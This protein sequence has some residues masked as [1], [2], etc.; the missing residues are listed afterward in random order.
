MEQRLRRGRRGAQVRPF[1]EQ[2]RIGNREYSLPLQRALADFGA[3]HSFV[4]ASQKMREQYGV[5]LPASSVRC[6]TLAHAK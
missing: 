3:D 4:V 2:G 6:Y 1:C 5:E